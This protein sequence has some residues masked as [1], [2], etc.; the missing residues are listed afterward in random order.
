MV[1]VLNPEQTESKPLNTTELETNVTATDAPKAEAHESNHNFS[2]S[3]ENQP[4]ENHSAVH[5]HAEHSAAP[6]QNHAENQHSRSE[7]D[8]RPVT[9]AAV[10]AE[11]HPQHE[12][13]MDFGALLESFEHEQAAQE[14]AQAVDGNVVTGTVI[15]LTD[16]HVVVDV[17]LKSEGLIPIEQVLDHNGQ[18]KLQPGQTVEVVVEREDEQ[19][20]LLSYDKALRHRVWDTIEK[21]AADKTP[22]SG[23][24][25]SRVKGGLTVDIGILCWPDARS[26]RHQAE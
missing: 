20:Y 23:L 7:G 15:K 26:S 13:E 14:A 25:V 18:P 24:V 10:A 8:K 12:E 11:E 17:G 3:A 9:P 19:G 6:Q 4:A 22:V 1:D 16:K 5:E 21:A 2:A